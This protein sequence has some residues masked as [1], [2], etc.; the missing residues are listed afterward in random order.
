MVVVA[1]VEVFVKT[2]VTSSIVVEEVVSTSAVEVEVLNELWNV[3]L[4]VE[5]VV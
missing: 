5:L 1:T 2:T 3:E 4:V